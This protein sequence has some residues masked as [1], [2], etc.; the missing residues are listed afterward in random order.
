MLELVLWRPDFMNLLRPLQTFVQQR[1]PLL[2]AALGLVLLLTSLWGDRAPEGPA[3]TAGAEAQSLNILS[4]EGYP[5]PA[6]TQQF[7]EATGINV[8]VGV[9]PDPDRLATALLAP[10]REAYDLVALPLEQVQSLLTEPLPLQAIAPERLETAARVLPPLA[11]IT[12]A[13]SSA[14]GRQYAWPNVWGSSGLIANRSALATPITSYQ[15][16]CAPEHRDRVSYSPSFTSLAA[17]AY[18]LG[19]D[20]FEFA[21]AN[22]EDAAGWE[23]ILRQAYDY[24]AA[25]RENVNVHWRDRLEQIRLMLA[26]EIALADGWD[27]TAW[28]LQRQNPDIQYTVPQE[29]LLGWLDVFV[30][31]AEAEHLEAAYA[32]IDFVSQPEQAAQV[33][34]TTGTLPAVTLAAADLDED[35]QSLLTET[36]QGVELTEIHWLPPRSPD[37]EPVTARYLEQLT[38]L[39]AGR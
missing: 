24:L 2:V 38:A 36:Y 17:A 23:Q 34:Q 29:G 39:T 19:L 13:Y 6:L 20:P 35:F 18:A 16:L 8:R 5:P 31:P 21:A 22:P 3:E 9:L 4:W 25:C 7:A 33:L 1:W 37:L 30:I 32:W 12:A 10:N 27:W 14:N 28:T 26:E 15:D 11:A